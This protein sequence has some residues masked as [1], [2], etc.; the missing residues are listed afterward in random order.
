[1]NEFYLF[2]TMLEARK[3][4][5]N[6]G[7]YSLKEDDMIKFSTLIDQISDDMKL[8]ISY[9]RTLLVIICNQFKE[10]INFIN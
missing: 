9:T 3:C 10:K 2:G 5:I 8:P 4:Q 7:L 6:I 1:M